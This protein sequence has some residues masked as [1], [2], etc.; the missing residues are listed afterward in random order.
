MEMS[1]QNIK[2]EGKKGE[3]SVR[4]IIK[5]IFIVKTNMVIIYSIP[6]IF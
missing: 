4:E 2:K 6:N 1:G 5:D 3:W